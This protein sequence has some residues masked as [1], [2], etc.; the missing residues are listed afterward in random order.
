M[1][2]I[3]VISKN[4]TVEAQF[5]NVFKSHFKRLHLYALTIVKEEMVA[6]EMVQ[7]VFYK[8]WD[9][10]REVLSGQPI[11]SYLYRAVHNESL[12]YLKHLK[13]KEAYQ[14][15]AMTKREAA[16]NGS[17]EMRYKELEKKLE[18]SLRELPEQCR[19]I[20][21]M[22]RFEGLKYREIADQMN[23][24]VKTIEKQMSKALGILRLKLADYLPTALFMLL[25]TY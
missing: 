13:V 17:Q 20:F 19:T 23:L 10:N 21:Q 5:E 2:E 16:T 6:E 12:N 22:S 3:S 14:K 15:H 24:S 1:A 11:T 8:L 7:N 18:D 4:E 25:L 9:K